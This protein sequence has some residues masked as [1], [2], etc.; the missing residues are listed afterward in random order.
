MNRIFTAAT[1]ILIFN[2]LLT[3]AQ[4]PCDQSEIT[5]TTQQEVDTFPSRYCS[6]VCSLKIS[7]DD[8]TNLDSLYVLQRIASL[9][10]TFNPLLTNIN[11]L[12]HVAELTGP[13]GNVGLR[14]TSNNL[15]ANIDGLSSV[16]RIQGAI[17]IYSNTMLAD[18]D[19]LANVGF[20]GGDLVGSSIY[21]ATN[22]SLENIDGLAGLSSVPSEI[23]IAGHPGLANLNG[24]RNLETIGVNDN[25]GGLLITDNDALVDMDAFAALDSIKGWLVISN[26]PMLTN[27]RGFSNL[28]HIGAWTTSGESLK[29]TNNDALTSLDGFENIS[30]LPGWLEIYDNE[31]LGEVDGL[32]SIQSLDGGR[33]GGLTLRNNASLTSMAG[34]SKVK[35]MSGRGAWLQIENNPMLEEIVLP[36][37]TSIDGTITAIVSIANNPRIRNFDK[38]NALQSIHG[39]V[40]LAFTISNNNAL[41]NID[42]LSSLLHYRYSSTGIVITD[43]LTLSEFCGLYPL[44]HEDEMSGNLTTSGNERN[45]SREEILT[46]GPCD[47]YVAQPTDL[48]F[49]QVSSEG[50]RVSFTHSSTFVSG[51]L[52]LMKSYGSPAPDDV[53]VDGQ[54]YRVGQLLGGSTIV[55]YVG[56]DSTS[57]ITG[58]TPSVPYYFDVFAYRATPD[59]IQYR[60]ANPLEG[61]QTT[62]EAHEVTASL[63][64]TNITHNS[65]TVGL[66]DAEGNYLTLMRAFGYPS[67]NDKPVNGV[68]YNVGNVIGS[69]TIVVNKGSTSLLPPLICLSYDVLF[70]C[71]VLIR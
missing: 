63:V 50:M 29:I 3:A 48:V 55:V 16:T 40:V 52:V 61:Y 65:I 33:N 6:T 19:G 27:V 46:E 41:E 15:L 34:L 68:S 11:G 8:I 10:I 7:G 43:N 12:S 32:A 30:L 51:Y 53:P 28:K 58:L 26:N 1:V 59:G 60:T 45:P 54:T 57:V 64:F 42:G 38:F 70:R 4:S 14:V 44:Y 25:S 9:E 5:L 69:S 66:D 13:C 22:A 31:S 49:S 2:S 35:T 23:Y 37:L 18:I 24:L 56:P 21:L 47:E 39:N 71:I 62:T 20:V 36:S 17:R 67:P